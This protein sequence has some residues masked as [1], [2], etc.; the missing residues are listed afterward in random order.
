MLD[1]VHFFGEN[2]V[3]VSYVRDNSDEIDRICAKFRENNIEYWLDRDQIDPGKIWK[4]AIKTA[5]NNG[6]YF[7]A[8][9]SREYKDR[10]ETYMN[11]ELLV[12]IEIMRTKPYD[13][14]WLIPIKLSECERNTRNRYRC[15]QNA[16][17]HTVLKPT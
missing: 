15:Q 5:I 13:S 8:C 14:G 9:F 16:K 3:F 4:K 1:P 7:L 2:P 6:A 11:E 17:G 10:S 12:A